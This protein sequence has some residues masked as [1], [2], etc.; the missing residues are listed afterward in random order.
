MKAD[1]QLLADTKV[2]S[3]K[4]LNNLIEQDHRGI[5]LRVGPMLGFKWFRTAAFTIACVKLLRRAVRVSLIFAR[6]ASKTERRL[7]YGRRHWQRNKY[8][9]AQKPGMVPP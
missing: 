8:R 5:K 9:H 1:G 3:S 4:Y 6:C 2:R 7:P